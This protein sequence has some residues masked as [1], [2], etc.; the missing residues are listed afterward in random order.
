MKKYLF[1]LLLIIPISYADISEDMHQI[2]D[3]AKAYDMGNMSAV[4]LIAYTDLTMTKIYEDRMDKHIEAFSEEELRGFFDINE[5]A[6]RVE[7]SYSTKDF[8]I[9]YI[10]KPYEEGYYILEYDIM[11]HHMQFLPRQQ[12][13]SRVLLLHHQ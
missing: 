5:G 12:V 10:V 13:V 2:G 6:H 1:I 4:D 11:L 3:F 7:Y 9:M 8:E